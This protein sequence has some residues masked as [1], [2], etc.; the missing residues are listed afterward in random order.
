MHYPELV[1]KL[2]KS[3]GLTKIAATRVLAA[4]F[5]PKVG[6]IPEALA[7]GD[8]VALQG[9]G[10]FVTRPRAARTGRHPQTGA[11]IPI[12]AH[13]SAAVRFGKGLRARV[14]P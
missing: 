6:I 8:E 9:F 12:A 11:P 7:A 2:A 13:R 14:N 4:L 10:V 5:D 3:Q 1:A